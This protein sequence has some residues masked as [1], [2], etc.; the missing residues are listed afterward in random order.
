MHRLLPLILLLGCSAPAPPAA[1]PSPTATPAPTPTPAPALEVTFLDLTV[2]STRVVTRVLSPGD[3]LDRTTAALARAKAEAERVAALTD[4][5][6]LDAARASAKSLAAKLGHRGRISADEVHVAYAIDRITDRLQAAGMSDFYVDGGDVVRAVG[7]QDA[8]VGRGWHTTVLR[9]DGTGLGTARLRG[10]ALAQRAAADPA[11]TAV[12]GS[13]VLAVGARAA[14]EAKKRVTNAV[15][16]VALRV[17]LGS[18]EERQNP[19]FQSL[20]TPIG[21]AY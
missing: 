6:E 14:L 11:C 5:P 1:T 17:G 10:Q 4:G 9:T 7:S 8:G 21:A 16:G 15:P 20:L 12:A 13:A 3:G 18:G 2:G 19:P